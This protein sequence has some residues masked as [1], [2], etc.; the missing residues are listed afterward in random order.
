[1][2]VVVVFPKLDPSESLTSRLIAQVKRAGVTVFQVLT[3][4]AV[5]KAPLVALSSADVWLFFRPT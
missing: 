5:L 4:P 2:Q 3:L 1:M